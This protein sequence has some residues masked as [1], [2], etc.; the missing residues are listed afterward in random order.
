MLRNITLSLCAEQQLVGI[1]IL[2]ARYATC[3]ITVYHLE[4]ARI[5]A[6]FSIGTQMTAVSSIHIFFAR[7]S[8]IS[9]ITMVL[10]LVMAGMTLDLTSLHGNTNPYD[11]YPALAAC[12]FTD[13]VRS[14][15][16][17]PTKR[18]ILN[19]VLT[20]V[21]AATTV[22]GVFLHR[23]ML[24]WRTPE[25]TI[26][27]EKRVFRSLHALYFSLIEGLSKAPSLLT[28]LP[29]ATIIGLLIGAL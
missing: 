18:I 20:G 26:E 21:A 29:L 17:D 24:T 8:G 6:M 27:L 15:G 4:I 14:I 12:F 25:E 23:S 9:N 13:P 16:G 11:N 2:G 7:H 3:E 19:I 22:D 28:L 10:L 5:L 1:A